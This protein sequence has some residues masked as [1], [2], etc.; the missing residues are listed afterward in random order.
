MSVE[1]AQGII[2]FFSYASRDKLLRD[3]LE[4]H[5]S[6]LK[7]RGLITTW[8]DREI[9]MDADR[10]QQ[11]EALLQRSQII[12]LLISATFIASSYCYGV[13]MR[14]ALQLHE[15]RK[16][17]VIPVLLRPVHFASAP[18][19]R[20]APLPRN[21]RPVTQWRDRDS[22]FVDVALHIEQVA[23][24]YMRSRMG[25]S[26]PP[27]NAIPGTPL[28]TTPEGLR[29][30]AWKCPLC[31][32]KN[33]LEDMICR[34][35]GYESV[36][37]IGATMGIGV[38]T[39]P[40]IG[41]RSFEESGSDPAL[42]GSGTSS[43]EVDRRLYYQASLAAC[44]QALQR[45]ASDVEALLGLGK[46]LYALENYQEALKV[47]ESAVRL[48]PTSSAVYAGLGNVCL[49]L[50]RYGRAIFAY[51]EALRLDPHAA[52][53]YSHFMRALQ[54]VGRRGE[55][56]QVRRKAVELGYFDEDDEAGGP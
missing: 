18:F 40:G 48:R 22:A 31:G 15:Q 32:K 26:S 54:A 1:S 45:N 29:D 10:A 21:G 16:A 27:V 13:E 52:L 37:G 34:Q 50:Q 25:V 35:C 5:L 49:A 39:P 53:D 24:D 12:L 17:I 8:H 9:H 6:M 56:E 51:D 55:A 11:V 47:Y 38:K 14:L 36:T 28:P 20:L 19:A 41:E 33:R 4:E 43:F 46:A 2:V 42:T 44:R 3:R 7:Y 30:G 23:E